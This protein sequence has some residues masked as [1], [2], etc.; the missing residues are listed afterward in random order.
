MGMSQLSFDYYNRMISV[1]IL[2]QKTNLLHIFFR[3]KIFGFQ[4]VNLNE[5]KYCKSQNQFT[6]FFNKCSRPPDKLKWLLTKSLNNMTH[7][8]HNDRWGV[9][10]I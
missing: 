9:A 2:T 3:D 5:N 6:F 10:M 7:N 4:C 1:Q 8:V